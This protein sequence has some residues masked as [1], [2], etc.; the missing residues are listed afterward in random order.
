MRFEK[1]FW[2]LLRLTIIVSKGS[3][4]VDPKTIFYLQENHAGFCGRG[5]PPAVTRN[6]PHTQRQGNAVNVRD[7]NAQGPFMDK[8]V[9]SHLTCALVEPGVASREALEKC[10]MH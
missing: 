8:V 7:R 10:R 2:I 3:G 9:V 4:F 6:T 1:G 5:G